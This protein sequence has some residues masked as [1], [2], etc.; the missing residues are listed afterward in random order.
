MRSAA[1]PS[2]CDSQAALDA[3]AKLRHDAPETAGSGPIGAGQERLAGNYASWTL[4]FRDGLLAYTGDLY[5]PADEEVAAWGISQFLHQILLELSWQGEIV[6]THDVSD[7]EIGDLTMGEPLDDRLVF[8]N[9]GRVLE[10][11][12]GNLNSPESPVEE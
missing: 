11:D 9:A 1:S 10:L 12:F 7:G 3:V 6:A 4:A 2:G 8:F 5:P